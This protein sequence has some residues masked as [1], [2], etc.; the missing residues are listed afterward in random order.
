MIDAFHSGR[1][2]L[3][4][5]RALVDDVRAAGLPVE[6]TMTAVALTDEADAVA[7]RVVQES[8]TNVLRHAGP[9]TASVQVVPVGGEV[10]VQ[11]GDC[12]RGAADGVT[13]RGLAGLRR[14]VEAV[15][16]RFSAG[17]RVGGGFQVTARLPMEAAR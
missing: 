1:T 10:L 14:R 12:G 2:G 6:L 4:G 8:L 15:G 3:V 16:G 9:T 5:I 17:P 7:H 11:I 13:G